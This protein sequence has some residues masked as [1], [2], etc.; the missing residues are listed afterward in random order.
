MV[1]VCGPGCGKLLGI[2]DPTPAGGTD[3][4]GEDGPTVDTSPPCVAAA[5]FRPEMSFSIGATGM[6]LAEGFLDRMSGKDIAIAVGDGVRIMSGNNT[7]TFSQGMKITALADGL[8]IGDWDN[9]AD[10]DFVVWDEG[11]TSV[12]AIRQNSTMMPSTYFAEQPLTGPFTNLQGAV[13]G[14]IDGGLI[15]DVVVKD[16]MAARA[17]TPR[18]LSP[19]DFTREAIAIGNL[20]ATDTLL[21][22]ARFNN[23]NLDDVVFVAENGDVKLAF[24]GP[25]YAPATVVASDARCVGIGK[26]DGDGDLD[27][28]VGT[29]TGGVI[30]RGSPTG[31][32][33][34]PTG[35][36]PAVTGSSMQV[37]D[38]NM[39][40]RVDLLLP[41][42]IVYQC[43]PTTTGGPGVFTQFDTIDA[44]GI[45][46]A[47]DVNNDM[48]PD[49]LRIVGTQLKVRLQQ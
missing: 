15:P 10:D 14:F 5:V 8:V 23:N 28:M 38:L 6:A 22:L 9:D 32:F 41:N 44:S 21:G 7:G 36:F 12:V 26:F 30:Y 49:L 29:S 35:N 33:S 27:L 16:S 39:D 25:A 18:Q 37:I 43:P 11:G 3:G 45:A 34:P 48:K 47:V 24:D 46:L 19:G 2:S 17:Y 1:V 4:G 42:R 20:A 13:V 31:S 40:G